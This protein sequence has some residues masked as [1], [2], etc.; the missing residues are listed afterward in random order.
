MQVQVQRTVIV[1]RDRETSSTVLAGESPSIVVTWYR[2]TKLIDSEPHSDHPRPENA[3]TGKHPVF[4]CSRVLLLAASRT[5]HFLFGEE[6][7]C[8]VHN[9]EPPHVGLREC[10][11][12]MRRSRKG[13]DFANPVALCAVPLLLV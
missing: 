12:K 10:R 7:L 1:D 4:Y 13:A 9:A 6:C 3:R 11:P 2:R 8:G 5:R